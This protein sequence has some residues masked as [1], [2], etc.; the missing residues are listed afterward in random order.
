MPKIGKVDKS[1][2]RKVLIIVNLRLTL[3]D[4]R[5]YN[6][7]SKAIFHIESLSASKKHTNRNV[8][9]ACHFGR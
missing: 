8:F 2:I 3:W 6:S 7:T 9:I 4:R 5:L 1:K